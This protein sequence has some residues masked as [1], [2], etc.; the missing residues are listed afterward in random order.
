MDS[1]DLEVVK[2]AGKWLQQQ[3]PCQLLTVVK[4]WGSSPRP[5]GAMAVL[6]NDGQLFGSVSGGCIEDDLIERIQQQQPGYEL[7]PS[8]PHLITYG[9][10]S[11]AAHRFGLPCG[12]S[13]QLLCEPVSAKS[14]LGELLDAVQAARLVERRL[15]LHTGEVDYHP[16]DPTSSLQIDEHFLRT[17]H[18]PRWRI[19]VI[20]AGQLSRFF[21]E[22]AHRMD[23]QV[24]VC[25]PR[26]E[27]HAEWDLP[28]VPILHSMPDDA[29]I[30]MQPDCRSAI[31]A[32]THDPKLDDLAL[33]EA[34][35]SEAFYVGA[36]GSHSN[37]EK[38]RQRLQLFELGTEQIARLHGPVGIHI[39]S[40]TPA[41]IAISVLAELTACKN[42]VR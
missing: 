16:A 23:Y 40:K 36:L 11:D 9:L 33:I 35:K 32:L 5:V 38:R 34:L 14:R 30:A 20:G 6:A 29:V 31:I 26:E 21:A 28:E 22:I 1:L 17:I 13:L 27:Y 8:A 10:S 7:K 18:G 12:G 41:E 37:Q 42:R 25:D 15:N 3:R 4:T 19:L 2:T 39:G 24:S